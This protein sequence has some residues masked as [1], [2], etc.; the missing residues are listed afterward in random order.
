MQNRHQKLLHPLNHQHKEVEVHRG[1]RTSEGGVHLGSSLDRQPCRDYLKGIC[2]KSQCDYWHP[3]EC[4]FSESESGC[5]F[6]DKCSFAHR[7]FEGEPSKKTKKEGDKSAVASFERCTTIGLRISGH[8]AA[9]IVTEFTEEN[10]SG[11]NS[12]SAIHKSYA[13]SCK[14]PRKQRSVARKNSSQGYSSAQSVRL[15]F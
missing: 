5:K 12:T 10:K 7:Q 8:R 13:A 2:A 6:G 3:P 4:Q 15:K 9:G 1:K 14:H 11:I